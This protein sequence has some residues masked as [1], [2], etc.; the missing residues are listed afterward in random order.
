M[1]CFVASQ[2]FRVVR[3]VGCLKPGSKPAKLYG[4]LRI[5]PLGQQAYHVG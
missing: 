1:A 4:R 2:L 3:H 5:R